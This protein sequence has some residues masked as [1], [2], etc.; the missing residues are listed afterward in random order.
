MHS[1]TCKSCRRIYESELM[2]KMQRSGKRNLVCLLCGYRKRRGNFIAKKLKEAAVKD[3]EPPQPHLPPPSQPPQPP[4]LSFEEPSLS[5]EEPLQFFFEE[6]LQEHT[7]YDQLI[8]MPFQD[9]DDNQFNPDYY[10]L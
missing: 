8:A 5:Y 1:L 2:F 10:L 4:S 3:Q 6:P 9:F 7:H